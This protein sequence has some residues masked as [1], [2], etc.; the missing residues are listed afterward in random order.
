MKHNRLLRSVLVTIVLV[1]AACGG[2]D[3]ETSGGNAGARTVEVTMADNRFEPASLTVQR[4]EKIR[5]VF[6][7]NGT[8][9]HDAFVG[10]PA[11][12]AAHETEM[13]QGD[14]AEHGEDHGGG[15]EA[16]AITVK[17]GKTGSLSHQ[18]DEA[19]DIEIGCHEPGHF[20]G[21]MKIAVTVS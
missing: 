17:P 6:R 14:D 9:D 2:S 7:N 10:D 19:G 4:G 15:D 3:G 5:F 12:Q 13:R 21:G 18:F 11:A 20:A 1:T 8:V 16:G